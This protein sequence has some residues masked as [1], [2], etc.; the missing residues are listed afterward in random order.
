VVDG[1]ERLAVHAVEAA[2]PGV[3][4]V[5]GA[6]L[7][8][9]AQMLRDLRL[10]DPE[11]EHEIVHRTLAA[12]ESVED[13]PPP[14]LRAG[15]ERVRRGRCPC[16]D[17]IIYL[18]R[19]M[20]RGCGQIVTPLFQCLAPA[21]AR[22]RSRTDVSRDEPQQRRALTPWTNRHTFVPVPGTRSAP[23]GQGA[24]AR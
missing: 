18:Y 4:N 20:S 11:Q 22:S 15:V 5:D 14:G 19:N 9:H 7:S 8:Q 17:K 2:P 6:D 10:G 1:P 16:H 13:L 12:G 21:H 3:A 24:S 23:R